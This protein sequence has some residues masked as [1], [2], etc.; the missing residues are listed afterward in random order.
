MI[1]F[2]HAVRQGGAVVLQ[3]NDG[4]VLEA[5]DFLPLKKSN[6]S[7]IVLAACSTATGGR[8]GLLDNNALVRSFLV[9]G[10]PYVVAS[11]W[12][13]YNVST[14]R[15]MDSF[16][17]NSLDGQLPHVALAHAERMFLQSASNENLH[18]HYW[19]GFI[20]VGRVDSAE[21]VS[22]NVALR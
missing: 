14:A 22:T 18:P 1:Y 19:A 4:V 21:A 13:V 17:H 12:D 10:V 5:A 11:Q 7:L 2:G 20:A 6:V 3:V 16:F 8:S 9:A 15:L